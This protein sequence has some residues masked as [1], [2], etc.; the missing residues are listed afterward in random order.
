MK[1]GMKVSVQQSSQL[2]EKSN[3]VKG[4]GK[5]NLEQWKSGCTGTWTQHLEIKYGLDWDLEGE[6]KK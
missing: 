6:Q 1:E 5:L 4:V 2:T 3:R